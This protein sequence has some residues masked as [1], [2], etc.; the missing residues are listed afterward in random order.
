MYSAAAAIT[1]KQTRRPTIHPRALSAGPPETRECTKPTRHVSTATVSTSA[2]PP[3]GGSAGPAPGPGGRGANPA[4]AAGGGGLADPPLVPRPR[5]PRAT[6]LP[7]APLPAGKPPGRAPA[8]S[9]GGKRAGGR[10]VLTAV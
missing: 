5:P 9:E 4:A 10:F 7:V 3:R 1:P 2:P 6:A 8:M